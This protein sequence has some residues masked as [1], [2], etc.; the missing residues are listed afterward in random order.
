MNPIQIF[1]IEIII[2]YLIVI[3]LL[4]FGVYLLLQGIVTLGVF[5]IFLGTILVLF[6]L[7]WRYL[8]LKHND[9][10]DLEKQINLRIAM[11][12]FLLGVLIIIISVLLIIV[13]LLMEFAY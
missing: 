8:V 6:S 1:I 2:V 12:P 11:E 13:S 7:I 4:L 5:G 3:P 10:T 9:Y